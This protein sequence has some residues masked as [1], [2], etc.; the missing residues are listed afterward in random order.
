[1]SVRLHIEVEEGLDDP[2]GVIGEIV[3]S[4]KGIESMLREWV[5]I[6]RGRG[7]SWQHIADALRVSRQSAWERFRDVEAAAAQGT[8]PAF[9]RALERAYLRELRKTMIDLDSDIGAV[10]KDLLASAI[11]AADR[12]NGGLRFKR[13]ANRAEI[14]SRLLRALAQHAANSW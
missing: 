9:A 6:A 5:K 11:Y 8:D 3:D 14:E 7:H 2:L 10:H 13:L 4:S 12:T 1:M